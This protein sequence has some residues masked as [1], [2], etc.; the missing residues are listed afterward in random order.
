MKIVDFR[1]SV[2]RVGITTNAH[3]DPLFN[4]SRKM[5]VK[6]KSEYREHALVLFSIGNNKA[7][8]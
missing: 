7:I 3:C 1:F 4:Y 8:R 6:V 2:K 5:H